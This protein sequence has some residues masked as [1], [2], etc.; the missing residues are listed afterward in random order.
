MK[1]QNAG[2]RPNGQDGWTDQPTLSQARKG[3]KTQ[4]IK[5]PR[6]VASDVLSTRLRDQEDYLEDSA[7]P[8]SPDEQPSHWM[9]EEGA[10]R[11]GPDTHDLHLKRMAEGGMPHSDRR[12]NDP[13][14]D[15]TPSHDEGA[16][17]ARSRNETGPDRHGPAVPDMEDEHSTGRKPY[18]GGGK[19]G[20]SEENIE[21]EMYTNPAD[22]MHSADDSEDQPHDEEDMEHASSVAAAIMAKRRKMARGGLLSDGATD[23]HEDTTQADLSRNA[24]EDQNHEDDLSFHALE[25]EN[26]AESEG[27]H[28]LSSPHGSNL[29]GDSE[30]HDAED[31]HDMV[32]A[33]RRKMKS[34]SPMT[35]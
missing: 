14:H 9:D 26:Y 35:R 5:H 10:D 21:D 3:L 17:M 13:S 16:S 18:A 22:G 15:D 23:T 1:A 25:K 31:E 11:Q 27:L 8:A 28:Q 4:P 6:M 19:I 2:R 33:I 32:S 20:D 7:A 30:E 12:Y 34:R 29:H 24:D